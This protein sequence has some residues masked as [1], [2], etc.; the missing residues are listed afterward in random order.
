MADILLKITIVA[1][2]L[3]HLLAVIPTETVTLITAAQAAHT[4]HNNN[5]TLVDSLHL[6]NFQ[7]AMFLTQIR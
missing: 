1:T 3:T 7:V 4:L 6:I 2:H 5:S